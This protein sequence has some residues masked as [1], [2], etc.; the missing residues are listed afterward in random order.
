MLK[1]LIA[2]FIFGFIIFFHEL[3]H[4]LTAKKCGVRVNEFMIGLGPKLFG[5][6]KGETLYSIHILPFG[7]ACVMEGEEEDSDDDR[8]FNKKPVY[9]RMLIVLA[10]PFFNF[11][12]AFLLAMVMVGTMG[13]IKPTINSVTEGSAAD[14]AGLKEGDVITKLNGY[15]IHFYQQISIYTYFHPGETMTVSYLRDGEGMTSTITPTYNEEYGR[16]LLGISTEAHYS[17]LSPLEVISYGFYEMEY[18]IYVTF[19][20]LKMLF[21]GQLS[22]DDMS[23]PVG[24]VKTIGD[25]YDA[26][27]SS[28][29]LYVVMNMVSLVVLLSANIGVMN[30][31][32][33]PALDGGRFLLYIIESIRRKK[34][35]VE[36]EARINFIGFSLLMVLMVYVM[37]NDI[38]KLLI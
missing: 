35:D 24:I 22:V 8:A 9:Q 29:A 38:H 17:K 30:L 31:L 4:F 33:F 2:I 11:L 12:L 23:G 3:G 10:G 20:S 6:Q 37:F 27:V 14:G 7:G 25:T 32:P 13:V 19:Q 21:T 5:I 1:I 36:I 18:Q 15:R 26:S 28:G 34:L 16:Y